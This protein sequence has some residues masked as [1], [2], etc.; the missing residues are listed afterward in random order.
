[1]FGFAPAIYVQ[2]DRVSASRFFWSRPVILEFAA[3]TPGYGSRGLLA[4]LET[5]KPA[6]VILQKQDWRPYATDSMEFFLTTPLLSRW[7]LTGYALERDTPLF[8]VWRRN[9]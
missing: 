5:S 1:V 4:D 6:I 8:A 9:P 7:L 2:S 3:E